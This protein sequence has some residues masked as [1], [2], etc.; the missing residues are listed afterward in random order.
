LEWNLPNLY[1]NDVSN[2]TLANFFDEKKMKKLQKNKTL[3]IITLVLLLTL[4]AIIASVPISIAHDPPWDIPS[5]IKLTVFPTVIGVGQPLHIYIFMK[6]PP[7]AQGPYGDVWE[8]FTVTIERPDGT[9]QTQGPFDTE[10]VGGYIYTYSLEQVGTYF[11]QGHFPGQTIA[12]K[13]LD[14]FSSVGQEYIGDYFQPSDSV[15]VEITVQEEP[16]PAWPAAETPT[17]WERPLYAENKELSTVG[18]N[19]LMAAYNTTSRSFDRGSTV[20]PHNEGPDSPHILWTRPLTFGGLIG[21]DYG[22]SFYYQ[23]MSYETMFTPPIIINGRLFYNT[24]NDPRYGFYCVDL[25]TGE[26]IYYNNASA[27]FARS[28][29]VGG[30]F[31]GTLPLSFGQILQFDSP[32]QHGGRAYLWIRDGSDWRMLDA[33]TGNWILTIENVP[34]GTIAPGP[35]GEI[36]VVR[37]EESTDR[38]IVWNST[39]AI[40]PPWPTGSGS[41]QWRPDLYRGQTLNG[42]V[43]VQLN[44]TVPEEPGGQRD[45]R[46]GDG[47]IYLQTSRRPA[48]AFMAYDLETGVKLWS[49]D[50]TDPGFPIDAYV[51]GMSPFVVHD[52]VYPLMVKDTLEWYG[53][54][55]RSGNLLWGPIKPYPSDWGFFGVHTGAVGA[56]GNL[57][58]GTYTGTIHAIDIQTG[59]QEWEYSAGDAG[60]ET[61]YGSWPFYGGL[62]IAGGKIFAATGEHSPGPTLWRGEKLHVID[63]FTGEDLWKMSGWYFAHT[64]AIADGKLVAL[65]GYDNQIYCFG[66]GP[67]A[68]T[69]A[70]PQTAIQVGES[71]TITGTA[72]DQSP[73]SKDTPAIADEYMA[74]WMEY[75]HQQKPIPSDATG[76]EVSLA[77]LDPNGNLVQVG[78]TTSDLDG[79]FGFTWAPEV[80][81]TYQIIATFAGSESYGSSYATTYLSAIEAPQ[82][83]PPPE[84]TPA[85]MTDTYIIGFGSAMI[86][87]IIVGFVLIL[88][89]K[90]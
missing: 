77:T 80:P 22:N 58:T 35:N 5:N 64:M 85:P 42:T 31:P 3:S 4:T 82:P 11:F 79:N 69:V 52:G 49:A 74:V 81:G 73:G 57:Y 60:Y 32:N 63:A 36:M 43:G 83:T 76:V 7:T 30:F 20:A 54:D 37:F 19:W 67:S 40:P 55:E 16:I 90:R 44:V 24:P 2:L 41:W 10:P 17:Y 59:E 34:S 28:P 1:N 26:T 87:A 23:G 25:Q 45:P 62:T 29:N 8:G 51:R 18:S 53:F 61:P 72:T 75:L 86:I 89:R 65:N 48:Q 15:K 14:P 47:V 21:E 39:L 9:T 50:V 12:G 84:A 68:T 56:Y 71:F 88:L 38:L 33:W 70:A 66:K 27:P 78:Q 6:P 46:L 13:N